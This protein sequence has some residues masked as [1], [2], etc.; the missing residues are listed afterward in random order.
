MS[1]I[2]PALLERAAAIRLLLLDVD[3]VLTDGKLYFDPDGNELKAFNTRDGFG[4]KALQLSGVEVGVITARTS[5]AVGHRMRQLGIPHVYQGCENKLDAFMQL[6]A[7]T[8]LDASQVCYA[9]DDWV[10]L[11][12]LMR[13]GLAVA[14]ANAEPQVKERVHWVTRQRGGDGAVREICNLIMTAQGQER[15]MLDEILK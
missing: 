2:D 7:A 12:V 9:G 4:M 11:P 14:V 3:G 6:L 15:S 5:A 13:A 1:A 10:D 8:G